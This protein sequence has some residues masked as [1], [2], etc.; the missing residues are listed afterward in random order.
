MDIKQKLSAYKVVPVV[1]IKEIAE[2]DKII[3][4]LTEGGL[5]VAEITFRT[6]CAAEAIEHASKT[7]KDKGALIGAGTVI[8]AIQANKAIKSGAEFI[9]GPGFSAEVATVCQD[10]GITY[11]P[12]CATPTE[13]ITAISYGI[14]IVKFFPAQV[15]G[16]LPAI[17]AISAAFPDLKFIPT[18]GV[19]GSNIKEF[20]SFNKIFAVGGSWMVKGGHEEIVSQ[21]KMAME[22]VKSL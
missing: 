14:D 18:G 22:A 21:C 2:T 3:S 15:Y 8:N 13:I 12:G 9:V 11:F 4:A 17:K 10:N 1:V 7:Y 5:P 6:A 16:G 19:D 20:L